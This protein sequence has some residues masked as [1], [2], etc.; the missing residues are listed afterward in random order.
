MK[1]RLKDLKTVKSLLIATNN[2]G[3]LLEIKK[4]S[5]KQTMLV[6][7]IYHAVS[8]DYTHIIK[9]THDEFYNRQKFRNAQIKCNEW[10]DCVING[11][12][13]VLNH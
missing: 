1:N 3:K 9:Q 11:S 10:V 12:Q 5:F 2:K 7:T 4:L 8:N 13:L 6:T